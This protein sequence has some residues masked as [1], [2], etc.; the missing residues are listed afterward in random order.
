MVKFT[1]YIDGISG[2]G[3]S[4]VVSQLKK[5]FTDSTIDLRDSSPLTQL[6]SD[7]NNNLPDRLSDDLYIILDADVSI[8]RQR[9]I[10]H[11]LNNNISDNNPLHQESNLFMFRCLYY[12][13]ATKYTLHL[14][15]TNDVSIIEI[16]DW[17]RMIIE[18]H[19]REISFQRK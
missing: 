9:I 1:V 12:Q 2:T 3:K 11:C 13:L 5:D 8:C 7:Q 4:S 10:N 16:C 14:I 6:V 17:V 19:I 18:D 15:N